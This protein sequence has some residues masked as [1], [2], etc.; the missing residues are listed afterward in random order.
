MKNSCRACMYKNKSCRQV[1]VRKI[2]FT[3]KF[4]PLW[5]LLA[6][7]LQE[8]S[9][10]KDVYANI[11][12]NQSIKEKLGIFVAL[13]QNTWKCSSLNY[14]YQLVITFPLRWKDGAVSNQLHNHQNHEIISFGHLKQTITEGMTCSMVALLLEQQ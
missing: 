7:P 6:C 10:S 4:P 9:L 3:I 2:S 1:G 14:I 8:L 5:F 13:I 12:W 11:C